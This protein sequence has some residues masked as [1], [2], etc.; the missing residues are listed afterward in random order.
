[1]AS[2]L[3]GFAGLLLTGVVYSW[4]THRAE[5]RD[6]ARLIRRELSDG[7]GAL[8]YATSLADDAALADDLRG[9]IETSLLTNHV[10]QRHWPT[11]VQGL[12]RA[13]WETVTAAYAHVGYVLR[14]SDKDDEAL[15]TAARAA[16]EP[17]KRGYK[18]LRR[19]HAL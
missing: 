14:A 3:F 12:P 8:E 18:A 7:D 11:L 16:C 19:I 10:W 5:V 9:S 2:A 6:S 1:M 15:A 4:Q 17:V 13:D